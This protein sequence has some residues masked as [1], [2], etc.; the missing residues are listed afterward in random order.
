MHTVVIGAGFSGTCI[1]QRALESGTVTVTKRSLASLQQLAELGMNTCLFDGALH[2]DLLDALRLATH[3]VISVPPARDAPL[4]DPA[5]DAIS[6]LSKIDM[7]S[8]QWIGY[9]STIGVYGDHAG[10]WIDETAECRSVQMRSVMR[11]EVENAW[12]RFATKLGIP[13]SVLR[14]SG[15]YGPGR[16]ALEDAINGRARML[17]KPGQV[18]NRI[19]VHD[20]ADATVLAA[21][22]LHNGIVNITDDLPAAPQDVVRYAHDLCNREH[23]QAQDF[24]TA[25]ISAMARSFYSENKRVS[26]A[27][28]KTVLG[29]QYRYANYKQ[30]LQSL[31]QQMSQQKSTGDH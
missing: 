31:Y 22:S 29:V 10:A 9:L 25:D 16:N 15:I 17:I 13:L 1:A 6:T 26:N 18:F 5:L 28:S 21:R 2:Q 11:L 14:L 24:A 23:P 7:P 12:H 20:L 27:M 4:R 8:L 3:L 19:H 30:G